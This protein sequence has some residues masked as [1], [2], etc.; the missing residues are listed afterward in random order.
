MHLPLR[1]G[2]LADVDV[3]SA[4]ALRAQ[5]PP[6]HGPRETG[7]LRVGT[8]LGERKAPQMASH[9]LLHVRGLA[10]H[11]YRRQRPTALHDLGPPGSLQKREGAVKEF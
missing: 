1:G 2:T 8:H 10:E 7:L 9:R 5:R 4:V 6:P 11:S 3:V